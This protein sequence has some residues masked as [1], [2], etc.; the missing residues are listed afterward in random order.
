MR[1]KTWFYTHVTPEGYQ[2]SS[3]FRRENV[4]KFINVKKINNIKVEKLQIIKCGN[5]SWNPGR[6]YKS[7][8]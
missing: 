7:T 3:A 8:I 1:P 5:L 4:L 6:H 2:I